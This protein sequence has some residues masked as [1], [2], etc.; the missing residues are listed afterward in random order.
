MEYLTGGAGLCLPDPAAGLAVLSGS[1]FF[2]EL[3]LPGLA[4]FEGL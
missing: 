3:V 4:D 1:V 2:R